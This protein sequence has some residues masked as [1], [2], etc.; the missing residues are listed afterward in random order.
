MAHWDVIVL[1]LGG[2]GSAAVMHLAD[3]GHRVLGI[4]RFEAVHAHGSSHGKTRVIRQ[5]YFEH[6][7]YVPLLRRAYS[8]WDRL[9]DRSGG[10]LFHRNGLVEIGP[11]AGAVISGVK[12]SA[13][14]HCLDIE[15]LTMAEV[16]GR[17]PGL[18]GEESWVAVVERDAGFLRVE[19]SVRAHLHEAN[20]KGAI[21]RHQQR[22]D[23]WSVDGAG[24]KVETG[25]SVEFADR[26]VLAAGSWTKKLVDLPLTVLRK[27]QYWVNTIDSRY[28]V[29]EAFPCFFYDTP[30]G[31]YYGFPAM[32]GDG[33]KV[34]RHSGGLTVEAPDDAADLDDPQDWQLVSRFLQRHLP[35]TEPSIRS[36]AGCFYTM[37]PDEHFVIDTL[38]DHPAITIVAGLSGHGF[39]FTSVL[40]EIAADLAS[41]NVPALDID[42][43][44]LSRFR[45]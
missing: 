23:Q 39:K 16:K 10:D 7:C 43:F 36:R 22:V 28:D 11:A 35:G 21:C 4:D 8:L 18:E 37:T 41:G 6:P 9:Q 44:R 13:Q 30:D 26:L 19:N 14:E 33:L 38:P 12:R 24:I 34:A 27:Q 20:S 15:E 32:N 42:P 45:S 3:A 40:G 29:T 17:W 2:V 31:Y 1:G 5:A 25:G